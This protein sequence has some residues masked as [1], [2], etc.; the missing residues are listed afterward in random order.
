MSLEGGPTPGASP[1]LH[2]WWGPNLRTVFLA[3][4]VLAIC[5]ATLRPAGDE[6]A[7]GWSFTLASGDEA[8]AEVIQNL[9][10]FIPFGV[11]IAMRGVR[12]RNVLLAGLALSFT[13]EFLQ[14]WIPGRDPSVG[15]IVLNATSTLIGGI[16]CW[17]AP[18]WLYPTEQRAPWFALG[19]AALAATAWL[20]TGWLFQPSFPQ[21]TYYDRWTPDIP[22]WP[23]YDGHVIWATFGTVALEQGKI[24]AGEQSLAADMPVFVHLSAGPPTDSRAPVLVIN[25][26]HNRDILI[27]GVDREDLLTVYRTRAA[28][29]TLARPDLRARHALATVQ[30]GD[31]LTVRVTRD[32]INTAC[33]LG[34]TI[35]DGWKLIF[36]PQ[37]FPPWGLALLNATWVGGGLLWVGLWGSLGHRHWATGGALLLVVATLALGPR[38]V[39]LNA[40]PLT[41]WLGGVT[42]LT[43][44]WAVGWLACRGRSR[45]SSLGAPPPPSLSRSSHG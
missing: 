30:L 44:G 27:V 43:V 6:I 35:G 19:A 11:A 18:R 33:G 8:L 22:Q 16:I 24:A 26:I 36:F 25:D 2:K 1:G 37:H 34:Y 28:A 4:A 3:L 32:C 45:L 14:Q 29:L 10:L 9:L 42:G 15:D 17:T 21:T 23:N 13:V 5:V 7:P 39:G 31:T 20:G 40:T 38:L 12:W 41:E